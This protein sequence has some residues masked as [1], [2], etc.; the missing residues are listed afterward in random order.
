MSIDSSQSAAGKH[1]SF[2]SRPKIN[3]AEIMASAKQDAQL[4]FK[5]DSTNIPPILQQLKIKL[6]SYKTE[7]WHQAQNYFT[8]CQTN[9]I[10]AE[11]DHSKEQILTDLSN[12]LH[13]NQLNLHKVQSALDRDFHNF[14]IQRE[15]YYTFKTLHSRTLLPKNADPAETRLQLYFVIGLFLIEAVLNSLMLSGG[16]AVTLGQALSISI[17]QTTFNIISCYMLGKFLI[18]H[19]HYATTLPK[20]TSLI[21]LFMIHIYV[22]IVI[23][24]NMG[25]FR[26]TVA[27]QAEKDFL[28]VDPELL[29]NFAIYPW[30][31]MNDL[32][33]TA[34]LVFLVGIVL[35]A[36]AYIDGVKSDELYPEYGAA[37][38]GALK[39]KDKVDLQVKELNERWSTCLNS[40]HSSQSSISNRATSSITNWSMETNAIEQVWSDYKKNINELEEA[41]DGALKLYTSKYNQYAPEQPMSLKQDLLDKDEFDLNEQFDDV[42]QLRMDDMTRITRE[43]EKNKKFANEFEQI[44]KE[45]AVQNKVISKEIEELS[46][47]Y[48][49]K[50]N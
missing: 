41:F 47:K 31:K 46:R 10:K 15:N 1:L 7:I 40:F 14:E 9:L 27:Q 19:I 29:T 20:K 3:E 22:I 6:I 39:P 32:D 2:S 11:A 44:K 5:S 50:L 26:N 25:L 37:Y 16:G 36:L 21:T 35:A 48:R 30:D 38:R 17:A 13:S 49:C 8:N 23:N 43:E 4:G 24:A 45:L 34:G 12:S 28:D 18:G 33:V 42:A